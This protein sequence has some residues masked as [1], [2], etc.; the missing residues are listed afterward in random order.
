MLLPSPSWASGINLGGTPT[1]VFDDPDDDDLGGQAGVIPEQTLVFAHNL[2]HYWGLDSDAPY[3]GAPG[4]D[5]VSLLRAPGGPVSAYDAM[6]E[7]IG[8]GGPPAVTP[9]YPGI[10]ELAHQLRLK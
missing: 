3:I 9:S 1:A 2:A 10:S 5:D 4:L 7:G 6:A 8:F